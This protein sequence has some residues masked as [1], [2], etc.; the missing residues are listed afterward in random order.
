M[1]ESR[2]EGGWHAAYPSTLASS[3]MEELTK[4]QSP[5]YDE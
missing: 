1:R 5:Q 4:S 2:A 3:S